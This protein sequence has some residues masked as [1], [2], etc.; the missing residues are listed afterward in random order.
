MRRQR[1]HGVDPDQSSAPDTSVGAGVAVGPPG[2]SAIERIRKARG[3]DMVALSTDETDGCWAQYE[4]AL[5]SQENHK[6]TGAAL[7]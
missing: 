3:G 1:L 5:S 7:T 2:F 6:K 4:L